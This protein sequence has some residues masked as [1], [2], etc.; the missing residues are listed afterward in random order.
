MAAKLQVKVVM[1]PRDLQPIDV[2]GRTVVVFDVLRATTTMTYALAAGISGIRVFASIEAAREAAAK[3]SGEKDQRPLLCGEHDCLPPPGFDLGNSPG[4]WDRALHSGR[5]VY[6]AT[7]NGTR[8]L[9]AAGPFRPE[10]LLAGA[11]VNA[12]AVARACAAAGLDVTLLCAGTAGEV[13]VED[14]IGAGAVLSCL[15][16]G[17]YAPAGDAAQ[18]ALHLFCGACDNLP[19]ALSEGA[20]GKNLERTGLI[21]DIT[22]CAALNR[23]SIVGVVNPDALSVAPL[24]L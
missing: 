24:P 13:S 18:I 3:Y 20:G 21:G 17:L 10:R 5:M 19:Q 16:S 2:A 6:M 7:T 9:A 11:I 12:E 14:L 15:P 22:L 1:V 8:A 4:Q 23:L